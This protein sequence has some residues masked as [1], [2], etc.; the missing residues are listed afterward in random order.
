MAKIPRRE[1]RDGLP[2]L[3]FGVW[4]EPVSFGAGINRGGAHGG[5]RMCSGGSRCR[6]D[7]AKKCSDGVVWR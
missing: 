3:T 6:G 4:T 5:A 1:R 2:E 7:W